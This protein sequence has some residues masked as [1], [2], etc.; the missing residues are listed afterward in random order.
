MIMTSYNIIN[1]IRA[2]ENTELIT[3]ILRGEWGYQGMLTTDWWNHASQPAE[4]RAGNDV[5][6]GCGYPR[7]VLDAYRAGELTEEEIDTCARR[8]LRMILRLD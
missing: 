8:V 3:G 1:G 6:M 4:I 5:K 7:K 2:S